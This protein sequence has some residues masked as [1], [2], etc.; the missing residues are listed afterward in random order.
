MDVYTVLGIAGI[1]GGLFGVGAMISHRVNMN[2]DK[3]FEAEKAERAAV[4]KE[5]DEREKA[6][7]ERQIIMEEQLVAAGYLAKETA[8]AHIAKC[9]P[10]KKITTALDTYADCRA[11]SEAQ[12]RLNSSKYMQGAERIAQ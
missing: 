2:F 10:D 3:K 11:R 4:R 5:A 1:I 12:L 7:I 8:E 6:R 9:G